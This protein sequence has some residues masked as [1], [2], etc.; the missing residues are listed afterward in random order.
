M[1]SDDDDS[2]WG[3][4]F[5]DSKRESTLGQLDAMQAASRQEQWNQ[6]TKRDY[7][8][9]V[10]A[11]AIERAREILGEAY[12]ERQKVL[13]EAE[14]EAASIREEATAIKAN[15]E[16]IRNEATEIRH[17]AQAELD[18]AL[19]MQSTAQEDG[20]QAGLEQ[21][22]D[23]LEKF[24]QTMGASVGGVLTAIEGQCLN[25]FAQWRN[26]LV[27]L[28][29]VCVE[30]GTGLALDE[31]YN[32]IL[33]QLVIEA[34]RNLDDRRHVS[35][36]V[37]PDDE[38]VMSDIFAA[39]KEKLPDLGNWAISADPSLELGGLVAESASGTVDSRLEL[40]R[41]MV[42][43]IL[44]H[45]ALPES[46]LEPDSLKFV[47]EIARL[48][49]ENIERV[50]PSAPSAPEANVIE[51]SAPLAGDALDMENTEQGAGMEQVEPVEQ[52]G[53]TEQ[54]EHVEQISQ[55]PPTQ[56]A[57]F[58]S[59]EVSMPNA[60][61]MVDN[62]AAPIQDELSDANAIVQDL[63]PAEDMLDDE[64]LAEDN[65]PS[66]LVITQAEQD[67]EQDAVPDTEQD[68]ELNFENAQ[69]SAQNNEQN[70]ARA[71]SR[72]ELEEELLPLPD[73]VK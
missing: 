42:G 50:V 30:K 1:A 33:E 21:A 71:L 14:A 28:L 2:K 46:K 15:A 10:R 4:I 12:T 68:T 20:F 43:N 58:S 54:A 66:N 55:T 73:E 57:E 9:K 51:P 60:E 6:R 53:P 22:Q 16:S 72:L 35:L 44:E 29:K 25:I 48:E 31:R 56:A 40:F 17:N 11:K 65:E 3:T 62:N 52:L 7:L 64:K 63:L 59:P 34:V 8:E 49:K 23:E 24:R 5:I 70:N 45:L 13:E 26:E 39:A 18:K 67:T 37:H 47:E 61:P 41:E 32:K 69:K 19:H 27:G 36:R 38:A